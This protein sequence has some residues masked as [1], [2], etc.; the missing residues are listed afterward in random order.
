MVNY[1]R[2][3]SHTLRPLESTEESATVSAD[4]E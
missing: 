1:P 3:M 2:V 4:L